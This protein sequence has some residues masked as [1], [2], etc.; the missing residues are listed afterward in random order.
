MTYT[1][2]ASPYMT[3]NWGP[4]NYNFNRHSWTRF[5]QDNPS[6]SKSQFKVALQQLQQ[7]GVLDSSRGW[8][9]EKLKAEVL[10][11]TPGIASPRNPLGKYQGIHG[12]FGLTP[13]NAAKAD[14]WE[15]QDIF[16][17]IQ[18]GRSGMF[19][20]EGSMAQYREDMAAAT[21]IPP[22]LPGS[23]TGQANVGA[24]YNALGIRTPRPAGHD[25]NTGGTKKAFGRDKKNKDIAAAQLAINPLTL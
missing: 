21:S 22:Q 12:N 6:M 25:L 10:R 9:N 18:G 4:A 3:G 23:Q 17:E 11:G 24:G 7:Q 19:M 20:P 5:N 16:T 15:P 2:I 14:G 8:A 13:Y 1:N